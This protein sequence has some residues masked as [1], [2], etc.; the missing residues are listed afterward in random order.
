MDLYSL[1]SGHRLVVARTRGERL[2]GLLPNRDLPPTDALLLPRC[3]SV[4][5]I[6]MRFALDLLWLGPGGRVTAIDADVGPFRQRSRRDAI[7]VLE[8]AAGAGPGWADALDR[9]GCADALVAIVTGVDCHD[10]P[11]AHRL[12]RPTLS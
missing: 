11:G 5:T 6:G 2:L 9:G 4:H 3:R 7:G 10:S 8:T 12:T 1:P